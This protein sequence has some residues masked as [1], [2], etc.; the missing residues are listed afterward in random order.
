[1]LHANALAQNNLLLFNQ[2][3]KGCV[4]DACRTIFFQNYGPKDQRSKGSKEQRERERR[5]CPQ[6]GAIKSR[7]YIYLFKLVS[8]VS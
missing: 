5:R 6:K 1:M 4:L 7:P 8:P 2:D 3:T